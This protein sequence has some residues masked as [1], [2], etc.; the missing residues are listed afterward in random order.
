MT[1]W[2]VRGE[3]AEFERAATQKSTISN[4]MA[5]RFQKAKFKDSDQNVTLEKTKAEKLHQEKIDAV[6]MGFFGPVTHQGRL[7]FRHLIL[8]VQW[9]LK[10]REFRP[11][12]FERKKLT[13]KSV[14]MVSEQVGLSAF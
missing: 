2:E 13:E 7:N 9:L 5:S 1:E 12:R 8:W 3:K 6:K 10:I 11:A 4:I 14:S